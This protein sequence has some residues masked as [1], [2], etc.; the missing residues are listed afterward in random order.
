MKYPW[1][2][3]GCWL[4]L[5]LVLSAPLLP[6][7]AGHAPQAVQGRLQLTTVPGKPVALAGQWGFAWQRFVDPG[8]ERLPTEAFAPVPGS[9]NELDA[10]GK[11]PGENGWGSYLLQVDCVPGTR[12]AVEAVGQRTASRLFVNGTPVAAHG[13]PGVAPATSRAAVHERV[14]ISQEFACP[15]RITLHLSNFDHRAGGFV[16]KM[17]AGPADVL[18]RHRESRTAS[19]TAL[20]S[21]YLLTALVALIF[22]AVRPRE[23]VVLAYG[24]FCVAMAV[25]TDLLGER[26]LLRALADGEVGWADFMRAEYLAWIVAMGLFALTLRGLFPNEIG[27]RPLSA[28]MA[29]LAVGA[30]SAVLLPPAVYSYI[31]PPGQFLAV[32]VGVAMAGALL[33]ARRRNRVDARLLL[34]G[35]L[36][37]VAALLADLLLLDVGD[38]DR[39]LAP[40]GFA[41]FMLSPAV[42]LARRM[43]RALSAEDRNR[44][45]EENARL[46]EDVERI[47]R[48][49]LKTPLNSILGIA[50]LLRDDGRLASD[51]REL[52]GVLQ[53]AALRML[54]MVNLSLNLFKMEKGS[55]S[56]QPETVDLREVLE[57]VLTDLKTYA[58]GHKV[59]LRLEAS[60]RAPVWVRA[61]ELLCYSTIANL[62]KNAVEAAGAEREVTATLQRGQPVRLDI[63][64]PGEVPPAIAPRL[65]DKY[66]TGRPG[67]SGL[68][69]YSAR[70]MARAQHGDLQL[71]TSRAEGTTLT[72]TLPAARGG[73]AHQP[74]AS[75]P[76][77]TPAPVHPTLPATAQPHLLLVDDDELSRMVISHLVPSPP[78]HV[79]SAADGRAAQEAMT[80]RWPDLVLLDLE[81]PVLD[82]LETLRWLRAQ[83]AL[84][85]RPRCRVVVLSGH[86]DPG[87]AARARDAGA[88][89]FLP[90]P[91]DR[92][93]LLATLAGLQAGAGRAADRA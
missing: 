92:D 24:L 50:R 12:L 2:S 55:Y 49:D 26:L 29:L 67:G 22:V 71:R 37:V 35:M 69:A 82:G 72:L 13:E 30:A 64:N 19:H 87:T 27:S 70:L 8:W 39:K 73:P 63:H 57:R 76:A 86:D 81:M 32:L 11:S 43:S 77:A 62:V 66:V 3:F 36:A 41:L 1:R 28:V 7:F 90:K 85:G 53:R 65:F 31:A 44:T 40:I 46:R 47:S 80:R 68:G 88:D 58:D 74:A 15:L 17:V 45:L 89:R 9:W 10:D 5:L 25:Y 51:Q 42:V 33:R 61:E 20:L 83:E 38:P 59:R 78:Y 14:P 93:E 84:H 4:A 75:P 91:V 56:F 34:A 6:A 48:H 18:A 23:R 16:R 21:A 52:V 79:E 60:D 54:E